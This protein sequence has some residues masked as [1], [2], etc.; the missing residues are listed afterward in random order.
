MLIPT[1]AFQRASGRLILRSP[2]THNH[3]E[4]WEGLAMKMKLAT[5]AFLSLAAAAC[6]A[7]ADVITYEIVGA[8]ATFGPFSAADQLTPYTLNINGTFAYDTIYV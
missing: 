8:T 4:A 2:T 5:A 1:P 7:N 3:S 6:P